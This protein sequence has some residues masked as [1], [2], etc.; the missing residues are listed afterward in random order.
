MSQVIAQS[1]YMKQSKKLL[2][3]RMLVDPHFVCLIQTALTASVIEFSSLCPK[4][5]TFQTLF[6]LH[7]FTAGQYLI[8]DSLIVFFFFHLSSQSVHRH[9]D[10]LLAECQKA[11]MTL[12]L[13]WLDTFCLD[14]DIN[15]SLSW[16]QMQ[17]LGMWWH[18]IA[19]RWSG[20][21]RQLGIIGRWCKW[22]GI[23]WWRPIKL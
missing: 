7:T 4:I 14:S 12:F 6:H 13:F 15:M 18:T 2:K 10:H 11:N 5:K 3:I 20:Y 8:N 22:R 17:F 23:I 16:H 19:M 21:H 9:A 1:N